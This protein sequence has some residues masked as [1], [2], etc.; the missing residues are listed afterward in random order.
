M[1]ERLG[2]KGMSDDESDRGNGDD[3]GQPR[4]V[5]RV[6]SPYWRDPDVATWLQVFNA[7]HLHSHQRGSTRGQYPRVRLRSAPETSD[8]TCKPVR[9]LPHNAYRKVW[10][11]AQRNGADVLKPHPEAYQFQHDTG[12]FSC[13]GGFGNLT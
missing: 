2:P 8:F 1:L 10:Y 3:G 4:P 5:Y 9:F 13:L 7:A 6:V 12:V 11:D